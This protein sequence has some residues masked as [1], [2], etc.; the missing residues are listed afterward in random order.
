M[1]DRW[2]FKIELVMST[3]RGSVV[4]GT[5]SGFLGGKDVSKVGLAD[6]VWKQ[7]RTLRLFV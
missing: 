2:Q 3:L 5:V 4:D 7:I 1:A 6:R